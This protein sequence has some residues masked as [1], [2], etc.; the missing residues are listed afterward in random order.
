MRDYTEYQFKASDFT[1]PGGAG[2]ISTWTAPETGYIEGFL[3][4]NT[5]FSGSHD[6]SAQLQS[7]NKV[8]QCIPTNISSASPEVSIKELSFR[9]YVVKET[10]YAIVTND[11][12][13]GGSGLASSRLVYRYL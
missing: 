5:Y 12:N 9:G 3:R 1:I 13:G 2:I 4:L 10:E 8:I 11:S 6:I 7:G